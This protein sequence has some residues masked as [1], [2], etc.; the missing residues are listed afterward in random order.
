MKILIDHHTIRNIPVIEF[1]D[2][3]VTVKLPIVIIMHGFS[4]RKE[5]CFM[6]GYQL[7]Q[8]GFFAVSVDLHLHG[9][10]SPEEFVAAKVTPRITE[11][12]ERSVFNIEQ[13]VAEYSHHAIADGTRIGLLGISLGGAVIYHYLPKCQPEVRT[14]VVNIAGALP[15]WP[16]SL[17]KIMQHY[18]EFGV[19]EALIAKMEHELRPIIFLDGVSDFPMLMQYGQEDP[20]VPIEH[21]RQLYQAVKSHYAHSERIILVEYPKTGHEIPPAMLERGRQWFDEFLKS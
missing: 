21:V 12:V 5:D 11:V 18:P 1:H 16:I 10:S 2:A 15:F 19:S 17:R 4:G 9:E 3:E 6:H 7:A 13:L 8:Q 20:I 14:A